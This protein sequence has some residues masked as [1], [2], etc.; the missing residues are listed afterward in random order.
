MVSAK[1]FSQLQYLPLHD[2]YFRNP[3]YLLEMWLG[4]IQNELKLLRVIEAVNLL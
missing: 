4:N 3:F 2:R 1:L